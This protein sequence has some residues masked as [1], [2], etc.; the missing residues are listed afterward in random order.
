MKR[1]WTWLAGIALGLTI[2]WGSYEIAWPRYALSR[3]RAEFQTGRL[4]QASRHLQGLLAKC[5]EQVP[6]LLLMAQIA[7][8]QGKLAE[9]ALASRVVEA[10]K[11]LGSFGKSSS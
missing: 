10:T 11:E 2:G 7:E 5:P 4:E 6:A 9:S 3:A 8:R 1:P